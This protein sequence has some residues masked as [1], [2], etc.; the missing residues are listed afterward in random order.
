M[1]KCP[2][3]STKYTEDLVKNCSKCEWDLTS[4]P[5]S[6][7]KI[8]PSL[9]KKEHKNLACAKGIWIKLQ[10]QEE[11]NKANQQ[12]ISSLQ[13]QLK[14]AKQNILLLEEK[15]DQ[16]RKKLETTIVK[17]E[18]N[19]RK[20]EKIIVNNQEKLNLQSKETEKLL[21][22]NQNLENELKQT[23]K[24]LLIQEV[25]NIQESENL[26]QNKNLCN[27][28]ENNNFVYQARENS[29]VFL[30]SEKIEI[31]LKM[32]QSIEKIILEFKKYLHKLSNLKSNRN[33]I[34]KN[35]C[36]MFFSVIVVSL[37]SGLGKKIFLLLFLIGFNMIID[38]V[39][40]HG[41]NYIISYLENLE[42]NIQDKIKQYNNN[43]KFL[44]LISN[45]K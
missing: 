44:K 16:E 27:K 10:S 35:A 24:Q 29:N 25:E 45:K 28:E 37:T 21:V 3:C 1:A 17:S 36:F 32:V 8:P 18:E 9:Q 11:L 19:N 39:W 12:K 38:F 13:T 20:F 43:L 15:Y 26:L 41:D 7:D 2:V 6:L 31:K 34:Y 5:L 23:K 30:S 42:K 33:R 40:L 14:Q 4:Y 22:A